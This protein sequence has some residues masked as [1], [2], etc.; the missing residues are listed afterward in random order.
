MVKD[1]FDNFPV[2]RIFVDA[3][4]HALNDDLNGCVNS[5]KSG[6][7]ATSDKKGNIEAIVKASEKIKAKNEKAANIID[8]ALK[9]L[10]LK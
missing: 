9:E 10:K 5:I 6:I 4:N 7:N 2:N 8:S 1:L 3:I